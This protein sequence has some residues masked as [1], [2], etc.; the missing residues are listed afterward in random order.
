MTTKLNEKHFDGVAYVTPSIFPL[1]IKS[2]GILCASGEFSI[3]SFEYDDEI[4]NF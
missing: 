1:D 4:L 2:E 3:K